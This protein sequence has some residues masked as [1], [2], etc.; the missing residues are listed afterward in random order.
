MKM[1][2]K[3]LHDPLNADIHYTRLVKIK[4]LGNIGMKNATMLVLIRALVI[5][6]VQMEVVKKAVGV[7]TN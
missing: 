6:I 4:T 5:G 7:L 1:N 2:N 3:A